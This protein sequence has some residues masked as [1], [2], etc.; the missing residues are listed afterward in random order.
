MSEA[1]RSL[2]SSLP[3]PVNTH[4]LVLQ[5]R[6]DSS[7]GEMKLVVWGGGK[8]PEQTGHAMYT[9]AN[10]EHMLCFSDANTEHSWPQETPEIQG[11]VG[12]NSLLAIFVFFGRP[13]FL[14]CLQYCSKPLD[15]VTLNVTLLIKSL[16]NFKT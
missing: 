7:P 11:P 16:S 3:G 10:N 2:L 13:L 14:I 6:A 9:Q 15:C 5:M 8:E 1:D 12:A 4:I